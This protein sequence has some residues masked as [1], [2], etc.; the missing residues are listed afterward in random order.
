MGEGLSLT[1]MRVARPVRDLARA[2]HFY[3]D[4][5]GLEHLGGFAGHDGYDGAFVGM[6]ASDWHLELTS[7]S[8]GLP[9]PSPTDEDLLVFYVTADRLRETAAKLAE[10]GFAPVDHPNLYWAKVEAAVY[11][12]PD[13]YNVVFCREAGLPGQTA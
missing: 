11:R 12:D 1:A 2:L 5:I 6:A 9:R 13:G 3:V 10:M 8:S 4:I 7:H